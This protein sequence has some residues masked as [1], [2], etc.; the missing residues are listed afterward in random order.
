MW[1]FV[2]SFLHLAWCFQGLF[3]CSIY[4]HLIFIA[5]YYSIAHI[6]YT[7]L[8]WH[9]FYN[10]NKYTR[11]WRKVSR[12]FCLLSWHKLLRRLKDARGAEGLTH[13]RSHSFAENPWQT[14]VPASHHIITLVYRSWDS[15][16]R[17]GQLRLVLLS[18]PGL[19]QNTLIH[20]YHT[21]FPQKPHEASRG[22]INPVN[23][24]GAFIPIW[25]HWPG[26][27]L[28]LYGTPLRTSY[29]WLLPR[30]PAWASLRLGAVCW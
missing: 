15:S 21:F 1:S 27:H 8:T 20:L 30:A 28:L 5:E 10:K 18:H 4:Q 25:C 9:W 13:S 22:G 7:F 29:N 19:F 12:A 3:A 24:V 14:E 2:T 11:W 16:E 17:W 23:H 6:Q 26:I